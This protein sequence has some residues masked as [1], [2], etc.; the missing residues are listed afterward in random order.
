M[1]QL[2]TIF[3][4]ERNE[5]QSDQEAQQIPWNDVCP[6]CRQVRADRA[7]AGAVVL[8]RDSREG[9]LRGRKS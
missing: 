6:R 1:D 4:E 5:K 8:G 7:N 3:E 2:I 9:I